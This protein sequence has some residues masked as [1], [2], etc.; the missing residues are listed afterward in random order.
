[1]TKRKDFSV[2][3]GDVEK[4]H[5]TVADP[6]GEELG[7]EPLTVKLSDLWSDII[8]VADRALDPEAPKPSTSAVPLLDDMKGILQWD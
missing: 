2:F 3:V 6:A 7:S 5:P 1:M 4:P 8:R